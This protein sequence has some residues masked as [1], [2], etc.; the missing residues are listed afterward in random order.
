MPQFTRPQALYTRHELAFR[1]QYTEV[2]ERC[3]NEGLL[4]PGTPGTLALRTGTGHAYWYRRYYAVPGQ[5]T[6]ALVCKAA[7]AP[8]LAAMRGRMEFAEWTRQQV[9]ALRQLGFQVADKDVDRVLIELSL[10]GLLD[11]GLVIVGSLAYMV[12]LNELGIKAVALRTQ[13]VD[14]ARRPA[15]KLA[16]PLSFLATVQAAQLPLFPVPGLS[17]GSPSTSVKRPGKDSLRIDVL[18]HGAVLGQV[19]AMPALQWHAQTMPHFDYLLHAPRRSCLLAGG[20][21]IPVDIPAPERLVWHKL[22]SSAN[23]Q[24]DLAKSSKDLL[25]AATLIAA[26]V[27]CDDLHLAASAAEVPAEVLKAAQS[28]LPLLRRA[29]VAHPQAL[30]GVEQ[31]LAR[32][33]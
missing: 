10:T 4:L 6:E 23:R 24:Q 31:A 2:A 15:L 3:R 27:E 26:L 28:R 5:Q 14:L 19:V 11:A 9:R 29:L 16:A 17:P 12:W 20:H 13:D 7:D 30:D 25:Q 18:T 21:C 33:A 22:F 32:A 1:T 8:A